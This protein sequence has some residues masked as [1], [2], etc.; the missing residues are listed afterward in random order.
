MQKLASTL[1]CYRIG[2]PNGDY[3]IYDGRGAMLYP[4]RW[5]RG[6][7]PAIYASEHYSTAMLE[8]LVH[9]NGRLPPN[10]Q[11]IS[12]TIPKGTSY[13]MV[14]KDHLPGWDTLEPSV[15]REFGEHWLEQGRSAVLLV[16]SFVARI[17]LNFL[18]NPAHAD[19]GEID[20]GRTT[21]V[22]WDER[23]FR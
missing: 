9:G 6:E 22:W 20:K 4:G 12:I 11:F 5:N 21:P 15:S 23:L 7:R 16:P 14:T 10:Q 8:K 2:D 13:E 19:A 3:P 18:I 1:I 17:E